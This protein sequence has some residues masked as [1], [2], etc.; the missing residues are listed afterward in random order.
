VGEH[1]D[2]VLCLYSDGNA[3]FILFASMLADTLAGHNQKIAPA[4][5]AQWDNPDA[6][7]RRGRSPLGASP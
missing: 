2:P 4:Q 7:E 6:C 3:G 5:R 1:S